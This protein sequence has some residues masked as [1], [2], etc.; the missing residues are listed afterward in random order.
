MDTSV[1]ALVAGLLALTLSSLHCF[2]RRD[3][4]GSQTWEM[5]YEPTVKG[6]EDTSVT[7]EPT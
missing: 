7:C 1:W 2:W 3:L 5:V 4:Y 6:K